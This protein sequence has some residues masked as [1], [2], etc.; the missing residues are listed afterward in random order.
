MALKYEWR[1]N[2][3]VIKEDENFKY[4]IQW[5]LYGIT[6]SDLVTRSGWLTSTPLEIH[7]EFTGFPNHRDE[8]FISFIKSKLYGNI[9]KLK[10]EIKLELQE[11]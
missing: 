5:I 6:S 9:G 4:E 8:D 1:Y 3:K 2:H 11:R 10:E 7:G